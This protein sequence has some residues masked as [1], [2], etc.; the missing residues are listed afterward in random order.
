MVHDGQRAA[1]PV[2]FEDIDL[3]STFYDA[4]RPI[5]CSMYARHTMFSGFD[6]S[7]HRTNGDF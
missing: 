6:L 2:L 5:A 3:T 7:M 4:E 1:S